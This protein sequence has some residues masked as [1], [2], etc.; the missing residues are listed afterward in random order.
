MWQDQRLLT[1]IAA[2]PAEAFI[3]VPFDNGTVVG[4]SA[5]RRPQT[6]TGTGAESAPTTE[7]VDP[8]R[9]RAAD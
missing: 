4:R 5:A 9:P 1:A 7:H 6:D 3:E 8:H 2:L